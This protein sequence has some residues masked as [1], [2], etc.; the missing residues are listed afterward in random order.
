MVHH[1]SYINW[2]F[3]FFQ[4]EQ[5][6]LAVLAGG[7]WRFAAQCSQLGP[8]PPDPIVPPDPRIARQVTDWLHQ[9][10]SLGVVSS[11]PAWQNILWS[12][13]SCSNFLASYIAVSLC[14]CP[15]KQRSSE[16]FSEFS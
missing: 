3:S 1:F 4:E 12:C 16:V 2:L 10:P 6:G 9:P 11:E 14:S 8:V 5:K 15:R 13:C 7:L